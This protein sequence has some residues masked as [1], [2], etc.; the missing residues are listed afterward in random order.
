[1]ILSADDSLFDRN[2]P[3]VF[4]VFGEIITL[5][6]VGIFF[7]TGPD[8]YCLHSSYMSQE[9]GAITHACD[10]DHLFITIHHF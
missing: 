1:M 6:P 8:A 9:L 10:I 4:G 2:V 5:Y 3:H 7:L